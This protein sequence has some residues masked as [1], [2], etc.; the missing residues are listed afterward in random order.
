MGRDALLV[1]I[2]MTAVAAAL[3]IHLTIDEEPP[4]ERLCGRLAGPAPESVSPRRRGI[5]SAVEAPTVISEALPHVDVAGEEAPRGSG[6]L[7]L[8]VIDEYDAPVP[9]AEVRVMFVLE[10]MSWPVAG[11]RS[12]GRGLFATQLTMP[13]GLSAI[14]GF[15]GLFRIFASREHQLG[16]E[17]VLP[18]DLAEPVAVMVAPSDW[19][20]GR[21]LDE[22]RRPVVGAVVEIE[23]DQ[24]VTDASGRYV[25]TC[26]PT[27]RH[28]IEATHPEA[29]RLWLDAFALAPGRTRMPDLVLEPGI[30]IAGTVVTRAG[31]PVAGL[32]LEAEFE[33]D[34]EPGAD[35]REG[36]L[37][38]TTRTDSRGRFVFRGLRS[39]RYLIEA[40]DGSEAEIG[41]AA[42]GVLDCLFSAPGR[43]L[44]IRARDHLDRP[45]RYAPVTL[46]WRRG[47]RAGKVR[48]RHLTSL[49]VDGQASVLVDLEERLLVDS[50]A[51]EA[52]VVEVA[53]GADALVNLRFHA[54]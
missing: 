29:G 26:S 43:V 49:D 42:A 3:T 1:S 35:A 10:D 38:A 22:G 9:D 39:G 25:F 11:G 44:D 23:G 31:K 33:D 18:L 40:A 46:R 20:E 4:C 19:L 21:V 52:D 28:A 13:A 24:A 37:R 27:G 36:A 15:N 12:D 8:S 34:E 14:D 41:R 48:W 6:R 32:A 30:E 5:A 45:V 54:P 17:D 51:H 47:V 2:M 7:S 50:A 53:A 16:E